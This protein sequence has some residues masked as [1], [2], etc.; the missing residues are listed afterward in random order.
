MLQPK[1]RRIYAE[2]ETSNLCLS[3]IFGEFMLEPNI[4]QINAEA[5][6]SANLC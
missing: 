3:Q 5:E 2:A 6:Y 1:L 4:R